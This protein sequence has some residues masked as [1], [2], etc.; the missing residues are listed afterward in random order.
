M[1]NEISSLTDYQ[2]LSSYY[3][4]L[5]IYSNDYIQTEV[6]ELINKKRLFE[7]HTPTNLFLF[8]KKEIGYRIY[9]YIGNLEEIPDFSSIDNLV[10]EILFRGMGFYPIE[11]I[12][13]LCKCGFSIN[14]IRDQ[15]C[16]VFKDLAKGKAVEGICIE[17]ANNLDDVKDACVLF[18]NSFDALSG[19]FISEDKFQELLDNNQ[20]LIAKDMDGNFLGALHQT[21]EKGVAWI[22]HVVVL[23]ESRGKHVGQALLDAFVENNYTTEKQRYMFWVQQQNTAAVSMYQK[24]GFKYLNKSTISLIKK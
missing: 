10:V 21:L 1:L 3:L 8:V 11:E 23:L 18:N 22:S 2:N 24:K 19:D 12:N 5:K 15:Y 20:I 9:Y 16:G 4:P 13:Y 7:C 17:K 14:L 6:P